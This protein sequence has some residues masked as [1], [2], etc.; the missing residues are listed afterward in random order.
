MIVVEDL[1][2]K[3][4]VKYHSLAK[5]ISDL[6]LGRFCTMLKYKAEFEGK[7]YLGNSSH[8]PTFAQT[9]EFLPKCLSPSTPL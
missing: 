7:V 5:A 2:L 9:P 8:P 6:G 4:M 1:A 3:N